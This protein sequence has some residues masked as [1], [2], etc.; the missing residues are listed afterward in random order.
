VNTQQQ[1]TVRLNRDK[2]ASDAILSSIN[3]SIL[4]RKC[5]AVGYILY[6]L[7]SSL[8]YEAAFMH[9]TSKTLQQCSSSREM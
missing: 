9:G 8:K 3:N 1:L 5:M 2:A 7:A 6:V 4:L